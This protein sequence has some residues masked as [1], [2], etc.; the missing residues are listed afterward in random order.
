VLVNEKGMTLYTFEKDQVGKSN[1][2]LL[3]AAVW[4]PA[5]A[6]Q[7]TNAAKPW[8][9]VN[10]DGGG[11]QWAYKG[12]PLYTYAPDANPGDTSGEGIEG[13]WHVAKP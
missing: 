13:T 2:T 4:P 7:A 10:R 11:T 3:C 6:S 12:R 1:C 9:I 8:S 5:P